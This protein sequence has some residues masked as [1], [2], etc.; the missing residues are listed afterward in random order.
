[1]SRKYQKWP[2]R[3]LMTAATVAVCLAQTQPYATP[4]LAPENTAA[5]VLA[6]QGQVSLYKDSSPYATAWALNI[7][8]VVKQRQMVVTGS[9]GYAIFQV[10]D[11]STFE[12]FPN[13]RVTFRSNPSWKDMLDL[14]LG[15]V[16]VHVQRWGGQ[17]N[18]TRIHTPTAVITVRGTIFDVNVDTD[19]STLVAVEEG[20]VAVSHRLIM[21]EQPRL[22]NAGDEIRVY[23]NVPLAKSGIDKGGLIQRGMNAMGEAFYTIIMRGPRGSGIPGG[24]G[25]VGGSPVPGGGGAP[26][27]GDT[28]APAPPP[29]PPPAPPPPP[30]PPPP[31]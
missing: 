20:Q 18:R 17:P 30:P 8:D 5:T 6:L 7:G 29:P 2:V 1:M 12:I 14:W 19:D 25:P 15:R 16:K 24:G 23:K 13:S 26:L 21:Q 4:A 28:G 27:P 31:G 10:N 11:G 9:D 22:L 3:W